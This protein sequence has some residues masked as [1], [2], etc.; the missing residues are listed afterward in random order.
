MTLHDTQYKHWDGTHLG[1][2]SRRA[3]IAGNGLKSCLQTKVMRYLV[4]VCWMASLVQIT[5]LFFVGQLLVADS[6][7]VRW[8]G[9]LDS[10]LQ[11][12]GRGLMGW[13]EQHPEISVRAT[14]DLL[15]FFF[16]AYISTFSFVAIALAIPHLITR[17]LSSNAILVYSSKAV[18]RFDYLLGKFATVFGLMTLTWLG[19]VCLAWFFGNLLSTN[20]H[21]FWHSRA[22]LGHALVYILSNMAIVSVVAL[23]ISAISTKAKVTVSLWVALWVLGNALV[24]IARQTKPWLKYFS[25]RFNLDQI[26]L[27]VFQ[28]Q[29]D[30]KLAQDNIPFFGDMLRPL[31]R[32]NAWALQAPEWGGAIFGLTVLVGLSILVIAKKVKPE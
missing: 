30:L 18:G 10:R 17:D 21:F 31:R 13:L 25:I 12:V 28:L 6:D 7:V 4:G 23:G 16:S 3:V 32:Q 22:A 19:P 14:Y 1:I 9:H 24:P 11:A 2:W 26:L 27:G 29:N 15:F 20:W 8:I 5:L